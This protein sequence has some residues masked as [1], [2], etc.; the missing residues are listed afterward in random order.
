MS[1][2]G[3]A[4]ADP[5]LSVAAE[6]ADAGAIRT[7]LAIFVEGFGGLAVF[8]NR[9]VGGHFRGSSGGDFHPRGRGIVGTSADF[10][11]AV[12]ADEADAG[13]I[14]AKP[15]IFEVEVGGH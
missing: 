10:A 13:A 4:T 1:R 15:A 2:T 14:G 12:I 6:D 7:Q 3:G 8:G 9:V 11:A 5:A